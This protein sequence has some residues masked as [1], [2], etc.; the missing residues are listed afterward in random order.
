MAK[1]FCIVYSYVIVAFICADYNPLNW[2]EAYR[3]MVIC[4]SFA[5]IMLLIEAEKKDAV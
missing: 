3:G 5:W 2:G 1:F 4:M